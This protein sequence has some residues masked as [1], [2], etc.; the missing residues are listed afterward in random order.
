M[1]TFSI[2]QNK[3]IL[4]YNLILTLFFFIDKKDELIKNIEN[5]NSFLNE[6]VK[7]DNLFLKVNL[8]E[9]F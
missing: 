7:S 8:N 4:Q 5:E 9:K 6:R 3:T 1:S 2:C